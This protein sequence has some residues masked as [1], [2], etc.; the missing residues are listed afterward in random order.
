V[1]YLGHIVSH[2]G[3]KVDPNKI[4]SIKKWKI[5]TTINHVQRFLG[6]TNYYHE[7]VNNYGKIALP[8]T[9]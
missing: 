8:L 7:F 1:E 4:K 6:L 5:P 2:E 3:I 9:T